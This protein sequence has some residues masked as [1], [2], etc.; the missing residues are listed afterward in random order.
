MAACRCED[1]L[2]PDG[3][4]GQNGKAVVNLQAEIGYVDKGMILNP[5]ALTETIIN[6]F[7][8]TLALKIGVEPQAMMIQLAE[9]DVTQLPN[10]VV[11]DIRINNLKCAEEEGSDSAPDK[12]IQSL[13]GVMTCKSDADT[14][15]AVEAE[16]GVGATFYF[17]TST[18]HSTKNRQ[19]RAVV[20]KMT[21]DSLPAQPHDQR[22]RAGLVL[23]MS[24]SSCS[25]C[26]AY[27]LGR[28]LSLAP[29]HAAPDARRGETILAEYM[30]LDDAGADEGD[31]TKMLDGGLS[32][33]SI[34]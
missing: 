34:R 2:H 29:T 26:A 15:S 28:S 32:S 27:C 24:C 11:V 17:H 10:K 21:P 8:S 13:I 30:P 12:V 22:I 3:S 14:D 18:A 7:R 1:I 25:L 20:T 23:D 6:R 9:K 31:Q 5:S 19:V 4:L 16:T 33:S